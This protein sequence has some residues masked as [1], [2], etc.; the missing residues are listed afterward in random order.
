MDRPCGQWGWCKV[1]QV[2]SPANGELQLD[3][4]DHRAIKN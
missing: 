1:G 3:D 2:L 4:N